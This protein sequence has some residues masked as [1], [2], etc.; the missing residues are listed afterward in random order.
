M[1]PVIYD[2]TLFGPRG[3]MQHHYVQLDPC[4]LGR[5]VRRDGPARQQVIMNVANAFRIPAAHIVWETLA[6]KRA[7]LRPGDNTI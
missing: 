3:G 5:A 6:F 1:N 4:A 2:V 7:P